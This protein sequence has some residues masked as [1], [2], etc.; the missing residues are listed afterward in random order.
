MYGYQEERLLG[1]VIHSGDALQDS[2]KT[3]LFKSISNHLHGTD[4]DTNF[5]VTYMK[6]MFDPKTSYSSSGR[7]QPCNVDIK[8][9]LDFNPPEFSRTSRNYA[10]Q[11][12]NADFSKLEE[13]VLADMQSK[14]SATEFIRGIGGDNDSVYVEANDTI[15]VDE[16]MEQ[17]KAVRRA[18]LDQ[19]RGGNPFATSK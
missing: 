7:I 10:I 6:P 12:I 11:S 3:L 18:Y 15:T 5:P 1:I 8:P 4:Y 19:P 9:R 17:I 16:L 14:F 13:R 2:N